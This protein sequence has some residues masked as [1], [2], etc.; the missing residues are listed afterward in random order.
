MITETRILIPLA[1]YWRIIGRMFTA[2]RDFFADVATGGPKTWKAITFLVSTALLYS[3]AAILV[4]RPPQSLAV[5]GILVVNAIGMCFFAVLVGYTIMIMGFGR[6]M[7]FSNMVRIYA[8]SSG[9]T[10]LLSWIPF[11]LLFTEI[12][13]WWLIFAGLTIGGGLEKKEAAVILVLSVAVIVLFFRSL[14]SVFA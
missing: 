13:K 10:L 3:G 9:M 12:W 7:T 8:F 4:H 1:A 6:K 11:S 2:P 5:F 14:L